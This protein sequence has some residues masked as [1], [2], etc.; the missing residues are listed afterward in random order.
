MVVFH[1]GKEDE[2]ETKIKYDTKGKRHFIEC[3]NKDQKGG[4]KISGTK[5][6]VESLKQCLGL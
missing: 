4:F 6:S 3:K 1:S 5:E 2:K